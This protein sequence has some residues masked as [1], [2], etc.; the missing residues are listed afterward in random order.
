M[1]DRA[2]AEAIPPIEG[3]DAVGVVHEVRSWSLTL[4]TKREGNLDQPA[5]DALRGRAA[6]REAADR[7]PGWNTAAAGPRSSAG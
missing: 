3:F 1:N 4:V 5:Y 2:S 6:W 7:E